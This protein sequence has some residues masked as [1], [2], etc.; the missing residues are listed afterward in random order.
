MTLT[1]A[2]CNTQPTNAEWQAKGEDK[3]LATKVEGHER[4]V[5]RTGP[6]DSK[7]GVI[8]IHDPLG[9]H[10][11][12]LQFFDRLAV[13]H[14]GFQV[15]SPHM[16]KDGPAPTSVLGNRDVFW[17]W[18]AENGDYKKNH[19]YDLILAAVEDLRADGCTTISIFGLCWGASIAIKAASEPGQPFLATGGPHPSFTTIETV[20]D[21]KCPLILLASKDEADMIP[22]LDSVKHNDFPVESFQKRFDNVRHGWC[23]SRGDWSDPEQLKAGLEVVDLLGAYF[24]KV[25]TIAE[26]KS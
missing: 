15:A 24:A 7:R 14:G 18:I 2:C 8:A 6:K 4:K 20:K 11:T 1:D 12:T 17:A 21:V 25:A 13:S 22:I 16:F 26:A 19:I 9:I 3:V 5:Y 23:G 10:A